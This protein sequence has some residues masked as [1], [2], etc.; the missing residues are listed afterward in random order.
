MKV[1]F[2]NMLKAYSGHCDGLVYYY[3]PQLERILCRR[4]VKPRP[5]PQNAKL[6]ATMRNLKSLNLSEG[7][8]TDLKYY[9]AMAR[10]PGTRLSRMIIFT[11]IMYGMARNMGVDISTITKSAIYEQ[12]L[13]CKSVKAA[14]D[15]GLLEPILDYQ[16]LDSGM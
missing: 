12:N 8:I 10:K 5:T 6:A 13:P 14:I 9:A 4:Y 1:V 7:Y 3:D 2:K 11:K 15:A 16:R